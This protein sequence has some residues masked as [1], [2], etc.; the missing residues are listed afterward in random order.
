MEKLVNR[1]SIKKGLKRYISR[2]KRNYYF[3]NQINSIMGDEL[4]VKVEHFGNVVCLTGTSTF[5]FSQG[6]LTHLNVRDILL[7]SETYLDYAT[8]YNYYKITG[9]RL[10][11]YKIQD[12]NHVRTTFLQA[13]P[14]LSL[15][16]MPSNVNFNAGDRPKISD[17]SMFVP[18]LNDRI[19]SKY[20]AAPKGKDIIQS[21]LNPVGNFIRCLDTSSAVGQ[22]A[23]V[24]N[25]S[26][27]TASA[28][29]NLIGYRI[30]L[31][32]SFKNRTG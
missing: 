23:I 25:M 1:Y 8:T 6:N 12:D 11:M 27:N 2:K 29:I 24:N 7:N 17:Y 26:T 13:A 30:I 19:Y 21:A 28:N 18:V 9:I 3:K 14:T 5:L 16:Y 22:F 4:R 15:I 32:C 20:W 10:D 31:Y